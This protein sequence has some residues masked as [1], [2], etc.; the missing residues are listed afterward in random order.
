MP[1]SLLFATNSEGR[2]YTLS[3]NSSSWREF[4][5]VGLEFK[6]IST[7]PNFMWAIGGDRQVYV[8]VHGLDVPIR[9]KEESYENERWIPIEGFSKMLLPTDRYK[10][11]S[12]DGSAERSIDKIRL[13]SMA[14]QWD[15]DWHLDLDLD[16][17]TLDE[18]WMYALDFPATY[19]AKC[20]WNSYVRRR[21]WIRFRR[22]SALNTWCAVAPLHK[23]PT[24]EPFIDVS[25]GGNNVPNAPADT[26]IVWAITAHG[27][28]MFRTGVN[29]TAPEG[30]RWT[31]IS[32]PAGCELTQISVGSTGLV[33]AVLH[34][35]RVLVRSGVTRDNL[36]GETWLDV[37]PPTPSQTTDTSNGLKIVQ[38]SVGTDTVW[39]VTNDHH[40]WF[41]RG[42][43]GDAAGISEDAAIGS[44]W[45]EMVGNISMVS[46]S[47]NDQVFAVG[48]TD[49]KI[50]FRA[51]VSASDPTG[52]KWRQLQCP[53]Q[54]SRTSS[55][56]S[57]VS[58]KSGSGSTP[59]SKTQ[60]FSNLY[61]KE[62]EKGVVETCAIIENLPH[63]PAS[64][65]SG[66]YSA[67]TRLKN[68]L[69][70]NASDS[71]PNI[72]SLNLN[73]RHKKRTAA[74]REPT[75]ASSAPAAEIV[76]I[77]GK[78]FET[79]LKNPRA[80]SPV[81][82]VGSVVGTEAHPES[83]STVFDADSTHHGSDAFL[84]DDED[85]A[86]S[87][88]WSEC[89]VMWSCTA[90]GAL[91]VD[92]TNLPNWFNEQLSADGKID[93][94]AE[95]RVDIM[96]KLKKRQ[97]RFLAIKNIE[98]YEKAIELSS[99]VK[100]AEARYQRPGGEFEDCLIELEWVSSAEQSN[101]GNTESDTGTFTVLNP[102]GDTTKIQF[103]LSDITCVQCCSEPPSPRIAIHAPRLPTNYSPVKLQFATD[104]EMEDWI[105]HLTSVCCQINEVMGKPAANSIWLTSDLGDVFVF[106][107]CNMKSNQLETK[108]NFYVD[109]IDVTATETPY[110][111]T[112]H[113]GM[114]CGT[115]LEIAGCV[116]DDADQIR[117]D[118]QCHPKI[119]V[120][121]KVDKYRVIAMHINPR[122]N[123]N[124]IVFNSMDD[125]EWLEEIRY[126]KMVFAPGATFT[127]KIKAQQNY[128]KIFV[129]N[130]HFA[131]YTY[132]TD[133][134]SV[135][136]LY[137]SGRVK[138]FNVIYYSP[139]VIISMQ[140]MFWRQMGGHLKRVFTCGAGI[141]WGMSCDNTAWCY[142]G[143]W[144]GHFLKGLEG[145]CGKMNQMIDTH[146]FYVY[147][148]QRWN[149]ISGFTTKSLPTDR[150]MWSDATGR[151]KRSKDH[152]KLLSAH[153]EWISDWIVDFNLPG[154]ADKEGWQYAID[155]PASYHSAKK[156]TDC[157]RRRRWVKRCRLT[158]SGPWQEL[159]HSKII[160]A[161]LQILDDDAD[162]AAG[163]FEDL[164]VTAWAVA[165]NGDVL[166]RHGV[167]PSNPR[168]DR[169]EHIVSEQP[170]VA[171]SV[172]PTG[173][174]WAVGRNGMIFFR[175][176]I[177]KHNPLGEAWQAVE[178]PAG[179]T[180]KYVSAGK[181]G[182][183]AID[184]RTRLAVR[185][186]I[187]K[188]FPEGSHWQFLPNVP[189][190][191]PNSETHVGFK[192]IS[193]GKEVWA[194]AMNGVICK[195][196][197]ITKENP[198]GAGWNVGIPGQ[199]QHISVE[200]FC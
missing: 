157:V 32:T 92:P 129:N 186:E 2:V 81:R 146:T 31:A 85:H 171:I 40:V 183:W 56:M 77:S 91:A 169:W 61:T 66:G 95:W 154:G 54:I 76:E 136:C 12:S 119:K 19:S 177:T 59:G 175:Y 117:F 39:C 197:G 105:S 57:I 138:L 135:T 88:F 130:A 6:K 155:F 147:E 189:S 28:A 73:E 178:A 8:H 4:P 143:G 151:Q 113:N 14:W 124:T 156:I 22:Y 7:V 195:R 50:L 65:S 120:R 70:R 118:L 139:S 198:A 128:Y 78:H 72:G 127:L 158:S 15:G 26:L 79:Q 102:D 193:V 98:K 108:G 30:L 49:R 165:A 125:S 179:V 106:D 74:L 148:N 18:G 96:E 131:D 145:G 90:A 9:V 29:T 13:P 53:M 200:G 196:C 191:P 152:T 67:Q 103:S 140:Q 116:Y 150:H 11:S 122:F 100:S 162:S 60:S 170:L 173:Q 41:R 115:E 34:N 5:Y 55:S 137:V 23:D 99:W 3:T 97:T 94:K 93:L 33:W 110:Y 111:V 121:H 194:I 159:S 17:Q 180:F 89:E 168:G 75:H 64:T 142:N 149:P 126:N 58:R 80:W 174:I 1:S 144:G 51:G 71:P 161:S 83:D 87:Q 68:E 27:R 141:V 181:A 133:P 199:W 37:K 182:I 46:V 25:I 107:P 104:A 16:G 43:K 166:I 123:E 69:W 35:G 153:C 187:T 163:D 192:S 48:A 42:I 84:G 45:V 132:R 176:G 62:K 47:P 114:P 36:C 38:V 172:S 109:K 167:T 63:S 160:D 164:R 101:N 112:L 86:G 190:V 52:K 188:T 44:G 185:K 134:E 82:S 24:Q 10:Y 21:K 184:N 20:S